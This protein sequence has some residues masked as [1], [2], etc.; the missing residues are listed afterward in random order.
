MKPMK[1]L[2]IFQIKGIGFYSNENGIYTLSFCV[3]LFIADSPR[4]KRI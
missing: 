1:S 4:F 3:E 2:S